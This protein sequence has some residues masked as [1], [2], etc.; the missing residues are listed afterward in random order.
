MAEEHARVSVVIPTYQ[1]CESV[2]RALVA[3]A[4]QS[5]PPEDYEVIVSMDGSTDGT[6]EM[7]AQLDVPYALHTIPGPRRGRAATRN[8]GLERTRGEVVIIIDD[9]MEPVPEFIACHRRH[10]PVGSRVCVLGGVPVRLNDSS[11]HAARYVAA[12]FGAHLETIGQPGHV[13]VPR[14]FYS[15]NMSVRAE[16]LREVGGF[17]ESFA[18]YGNEDVDLG[19]RLRYAGVELRYDPEARADQSYEKE[20][21]GLADDIHGDGRTTVQLALR[22]PDLFDELRL[23]PDDHE[24]PWLA[25]RSV[26]LSLTRR[27]PSLVRYVFAA[28]AALERLGLWRAPLYYRAVLDYAYWSGVDGAARKLPDPGPLAPIVAELRR[29]PIDLL[30]HR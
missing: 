12:K 13:F 10:H 27:W 11:P 3:L 18:V 22:H 20:L 23:A 17:D 28:A 29:G 4:R 5:T 6:A 19:V 30:L 14:D 24:R 15:G 26:L 1:R 9:D 16:V 2:R 21:G 7:L 25:V 8:A